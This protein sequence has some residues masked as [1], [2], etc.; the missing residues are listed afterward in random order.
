MAHESLAGQSAATPAS[1]V[2]AAGG[3]EV[4]AA[5]DHLVAAAVTVLGWDGAVLPPVLLL[6][7]RVV[8][9]AELDGLAHSQRIATGWAPV[10]DRTSVSTWHW[11]EMAHLVPPPAVQL[12]GL[13]APARHWRTGLAAAGPFT[14]LCATAMLLPADVAR[15][16]QCLRQADRF[17]PTV[18]ATA[19][20]SDVDPDAVDVVQPGRPG[21]MPCTRPPVVSRWV[22]EVVYEQLLA[23]AA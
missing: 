4:L 23:Q 18:V 1:R 16:A 6:G 11:P 15:D 14:G 9:V 12:R 22:H 7:R 21:P 13:V 2:H 10:T 5:P 3:V 8:V 20:V 19:G 17:G